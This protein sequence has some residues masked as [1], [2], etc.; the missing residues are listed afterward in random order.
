M[1]DAVQAVAEI[2]RQKTEAETLQHDSNFHYD[3]ASKLYAGASFLKENPLFDQ[4]IR[5]IKDGS[6]SL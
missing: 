2:K 5:L 1:D 4:F 3:R 6:L